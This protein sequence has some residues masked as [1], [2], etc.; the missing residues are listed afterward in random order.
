MA[1]ARTAQADQ[2]CERHLHPLK[3][4]QFDP[5]FGEF[6]L[7]PCTRLS[8]ARPVL[9]LQQLRRF[10]QTEAQALG[11]LD[12]GKRSTNHVFPQST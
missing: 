10:V 2:I 6:G 5:D 4:C 1:A 11:G 9:K 8:T 7:R 3:V 12:E